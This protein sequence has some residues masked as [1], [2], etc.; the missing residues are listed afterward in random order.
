[1]PRKEKGVKVALIVLV[2]VLVLGILVAGVRFYTLKKIE[3]ACEACLDG[4]SPGE[5]HPLSKYPKEAIDYLFKT[6]DYKS[7]VEKIDSLVLV[8]II[9]EI[10][11]ESIPNSTLDSL[12]WPRR[13]PGV[14]DANLEKIVDQIKSWWQKHRHELSSNWWP[15]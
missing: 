4:E 7:T 13:R 9:V 10:S 5:G 2:G 1:M 6:L 11:S 3:D 12:E 15:W 8:A 14:K